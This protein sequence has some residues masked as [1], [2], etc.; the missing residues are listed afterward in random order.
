MDHEDILTSKRMVVA[1]NRLPVVINELQVHPASGG[2]VTAFAPL[3][4]KNRG[5][6]VGWP[7]TIDLEE[8]QIKDL[9]S[10]YSAQAGYHLHPVTLSQEEVKLFYEGFSNEVIWPLFH[11]LQTECNFEPKFWD[12]YQKVNK[13]FAKVLFP[14][15][16]KEDILWVQDYQLM[17]VGEEIRKERPPCNLAFFLHIPFAS[18]DIFMKIPWRVEILRGLLNYDFIGFQT[19]H[20]QRNFIQCVTHLLHDV[21]IISRDMYFFCCFE[22]REVCIGT[23]P[24]SIDYNEFADM[25]ESDH[26]SEE[27]HSLR[28]ILEDKK[29]IF[30]IDRLDYTKG[31]LCRLQGIRSFLE[32]YPEFHEQVIFFQVIIPSRVHILE[33]QE[34]KE[35]IDKEV[36]EI[37]S[38]W[39]K[40]GWVPIHYM[41]HSLSREEL[42]TYYR[43]ADVVLVTS[44]K[45]GMNLVAKEYV[46]SNANE[47]GVV[48]LSE[49]VGAAAEM[50]HDALLVNPYDREGVSK[51]IHQALIMPQ[52]ERHLRMQSLREGVRKENVYKWA[53]SIL[54]EIVTQKA[55][56]YRH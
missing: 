27:V 10:D 9:L 15:L 3:L 43:A 34:L 16:K 44:L 24:I 26:I 22:G 47:D 8:G 30:S 20:D 33:Y 29:I 4:K 13:K 25:A 54:S 51:S 39:T 14:L 32:A 17:L 46:A 28:A 55:H 12:C 48:V 40:P 11:D 18:L 31:I 41:F 7:G 36:S 56:R 53:S 38:T 50:R 5:E 1:S 42:V 21:T 49:F 23:F 37:N 6:W 52:E 19:R 35:K 2:L 45:D